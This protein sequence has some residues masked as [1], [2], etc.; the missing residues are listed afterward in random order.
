M[1]VL[2]KCLV[3]SKYAES[4]Q[5]TQYTAPT[6]TRTILDKITAYNGYASSVV[7]TINMVASGGSAGASNIAIVKSMASG[8]TYTFPEVVG[9]VLNAGD[10]I[11]TLAG[12]AS[13]VV[14]RIGGREVS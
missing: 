1:T 8:E 13:A 2:A 7:L 12:T 5:T 11:S 3:E 4:S 6:S 9:H 10:F 14:I